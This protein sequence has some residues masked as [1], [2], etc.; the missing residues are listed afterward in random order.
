MKQAD[1]DHGHIVAADAAGFAV[2][3]QAIV[4][5]VFANGV[6]FLLG[7]DAS[8]DEFDDS[9]RGLAIPD[10]CK[11]SDDVFERASQ[12]VHTVARDNEE[13]VILGNVMHR[14]VG[15]GGDDLLLRRQIGALLEFKVANSSAQGEVAVDAA[16]V[17]EST[18]GADASL[19]AFILRLVVKGEGLGA[20]LDAENGSRVASI[21]LTVSVDRMRGGCERRDLRR[22]FCPL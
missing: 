13:L 20:A 21:A 19:F 14:H 5:H 16:E 15:E 8:S 17:D 7:G 22:R 2:A 1:N 3:G 6:Q 4:H 12:Q 11:L 18:G 10:A 9:L